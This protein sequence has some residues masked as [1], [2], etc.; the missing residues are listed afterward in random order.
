MRILN[1]E[2]KDNNKL[3]IQFN[4]VVGLQSFNIKTT[5]EFDDY[6]KH[7]DPNLNK[8]L[9]TYNQRTIYIENMILMVCGKVHIMW[10]DDKTVIIEGSFSLDIL[11]SLIN[12]LKL[13]NINTIIDIEPSLIKNNPQAILELR[14]RFNKYEYYFNKFPVSCRIDVRKDV[15]AIKTISMM[16]NSEENIIDYKYIKKDSG[17]DF[18]PLSICLIQITN[19]NDE[20]IKSLVYHGIACHPFRDCLVLTY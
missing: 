4:N 15:S 20:S 12:D 11:T 7:I 2:Y 13:I 9:K 19:I 5:K 6:K 10:K 14:D 18:L 8:S 16:V 1:Y 3:T 17:F